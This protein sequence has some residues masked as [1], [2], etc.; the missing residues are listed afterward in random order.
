MFQF[1]SWSIKK[2]ICV[3]TNSGMKTVLEEKDKEL[4]KAKS[5]SS[6]L[7]SQQQ[8]ARSS[9]KPEITMNPELQKLADDLK[10]QLHSKEN[11]LLEVDLKLQFAERK[12][13]TY[14]SHVSHLRERVNNLEAQLEQTTKVNISFNS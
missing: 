13:G 10:L 3:K 6:S 11:Q 2:Y 5:M 9:S 1:E 12:V 4:T 14:D 7:I 8:D